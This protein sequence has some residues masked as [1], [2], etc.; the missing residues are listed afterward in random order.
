M[1]FN[2]NNKL[3]VID[4]FQI[5]SFSFKNVGKNDF[6]YLSYEFDSNVLDL[7]KQKPFYPL[8]IWVILKSVKNSY[9]AKKGFIVRE[10]VKIIVI[11]NM[12]MC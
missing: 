3:I 7:V 5:L 1:S 9:Q 2:L 8:H 12:N 6:K 10:L 4:S 11:K